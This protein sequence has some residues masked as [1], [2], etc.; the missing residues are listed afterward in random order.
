[1]NIGNS[2]TDIP[3]GFLTAD[4]VSVTKIVI[5]ESVQVIPFEAFTLAPNLASVTLNANLSSEIAFGT[6]G[7]TNPIKTVIIG[8]N[9]TRIK[10]DTFSYA[11]ITS[12]DLRNVVI[13]EGGAFA[14]TTLNSL[15]IPASVEL[16]GA[17]A[18]NGLETA[19]Q[20]VTFAKAIVSIADDNSFPGGNGTGAAELSLKE[21]YEDRDPANPEVGGAGRYVNGA[22]TGTFGWEKRP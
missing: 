17:N 19:L 8:P 12:I 14:N 9:V 21:A 6:V 18:F 2:V 3:E 15:F 20:E 11:K 4:H 10:K 5:P 16:I 22:V 1:M 7:D 13:I